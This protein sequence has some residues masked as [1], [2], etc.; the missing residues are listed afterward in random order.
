VK[1]KFAIILMTTFANITDQAEGCTTLAFNSNESVFMAKSYDWSQGHGFLIVNKKNVQKRSM[2]LSGSKTVEWV[3]N[4]GSVTF[5]Q[6]ARELPSGGINEKGLAIE[7]MWLE[8]GEYPAPKPGTS[9][10]NEL[11]WIQFQLDNY[12]SV[13]E[14]MNN[15]QKLPIQKAVAPLHYFICDPSECGIVDFEKGK[16]Q[17]YYGKTLSAKALSNATYNESLQNFKKL[18]RTSKAPSS[19]D[20]S[21]N[22]FIRAA[23]Y[24]ANSFGTKNPE[25]YAFE[26]L[27]SVE[28]PTD[29]RDPLWGYSQWNIVYDTG[30]KIVHF[31]TQAVPTIRTLEVSSLN[32]DCKD[33]VMVLSLDS[34]LEGNVNSKLKPYKTSDNAEIVKES[35]KFL[36]GQVPPKLFASME[37]GMIFYPESTKCIPQKVK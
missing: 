31:K 33:P 35:L 25:S 37:K 26:A 16:L 11:Q 5:N 24:S 29:R 15:V 23:R 30:K 3:S 13:A 7:L 17:T 20:S 34:S 14:V 9:A 32:F 12:S 1:T 28:I 6:Q 36:K 8:N 19:G 21:I 10:I 27:K 22:R 4:F 18:A 2:S